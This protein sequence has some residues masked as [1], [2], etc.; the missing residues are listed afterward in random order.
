MLQ[1]ASL[2]QFDTGPDQAVGADG[3]AGTNLRSGINNGSP[4][5]L[6]IAHLSRKVNM[7]SPSETTA[8]LTTQLQCAFASRLLR[9]LISST[10]MKCMSPGNTG[11]RNFTAYALIK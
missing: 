6:D 7:R 5:N 1:P 9:A 8:S 11:L 3:R 2:T 10:C 4:V